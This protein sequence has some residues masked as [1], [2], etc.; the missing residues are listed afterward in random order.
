MRGV[1]E[2]TVFQYQHRSY[3][4]KQI[5]FHYYTCSYCCN[6]RL[7]HNFCSDKIYLTKY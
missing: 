1:F 7:G 4:L 3:M 5:S 6:L 2:T